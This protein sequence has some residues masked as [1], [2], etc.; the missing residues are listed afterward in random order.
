MTRIEVC[1]KNRK[2]NHQQSKRQPFRDAASHLGTCFL[3]PT[4]L[5]THTP[6][7]EP[8]SL[9]LLMVIGLISDEKWCGILLR[10]IVPPAQSRL[11][12]EAQIFPAR[13]PFIPH[14]SVSLALWDNVVP[15]KKERN[16]E[17]YCLSNIIFVSLPKNDPE[18]KTGVALLEI[19]SVVPRRQSTLMFPSFTSLQLPVPMLEW[20]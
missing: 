19:T 13:D 11:G 4:L 8:L 5:H 17:L 12:R 9:A 2:L 10:T 1:H 18:R 3:P 14:T 20:C 15:K 7:C 6:D 16:T